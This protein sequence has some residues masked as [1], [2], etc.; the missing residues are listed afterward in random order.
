MFAMEG[1]FALFIMI[2]NEIHLVAKHV[3]VYK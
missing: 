1:R 3:T 2:Q